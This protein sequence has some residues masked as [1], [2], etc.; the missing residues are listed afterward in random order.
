MSA[1]ARLLLA[2]GIAV[3]GSDLNANEQTLQ[4]QAQ[5]MPFYPGHCAEN[6]QDGCDLV[7]HT[8]AAKPENPEL[9]QAKARG[10]PT[11][12]RAQLLATLLANHRLTAVAGTHGKTT[13]T[14]MLAHMATA[15]CDPLVV[16]GGI[17]QHHHS[18]LILG[19]DLLALVEVDESDG[20]FLSFHPHA[21]VVT[22]IEREHVD[23]Y[24]GG[25]Q[26]LL[27][28]FLQ[29]LQGTKE[30]GPILMNADD[31]LCGHPSFQE[32]PHRLTFGLHNRGDFVAEELKISRSGSHFRLA[33][34]YGDALQV[35][36]NVPGHHNI[37]NAVAAIGILALQGYPLDALTDALP[38]FS[39]P[40]RRFQDLG[41]AGGCH[42]IDDYAHHPTEIRTTLA[43]AKAL[44]PKDPIVAIFQP[45]RFT[46]FEA[47]WE[48]FLQAF[49]QA[50]EIVV[51]P[52]YTASEVPVAG[53]T[54]EDFCTALKKNHPQVSAL[55]HT[56]DLPGHM[57][58]LKG[59]K[60][61]IVGLGAGSISRLI[62]ELLSRWLTDDK[63]EL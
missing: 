36:L 34:P 19:S 62:H 53:I 12:P 4:L 56:N 39:L 58:H 24:R 8:S 44:W 51:L 15:I 25:E 49:V 27:D 23:H 20:S 13:T 18:N 32:L 35:H 22:N 63:R 2:Q 45:H 38:T 7:C 52:V 50:D 43:T 16:A 9:L 17:L 11:M 5:G 28:R 26:D 55:A 33:H 41:M 57:A 47:L 21:S 10:I 3:T 30:T 29:F 6:L 46:R 59:S 61:H 1:L 31:R 48:D 14:A 42:F 54:A 37:A 40:L 60:A